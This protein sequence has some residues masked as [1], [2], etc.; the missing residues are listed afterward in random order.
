[1]VG[2]PQR[3]T[4]PAIAL[5]LRTSVALLLAASVPAA[6]G[7]PAPFTVSGSCRDARPH[8]AYEVHMQDG[9]LRVSGAFNQGKRI[10]SF[11]FWSSTGVRLALLPFDDDVMSG[12]VALWYATAPAKGE[13]PRKLE[14]V[15]VSGHPVSARSWY[16]DG[17][18]RAEFRYEKDALAEARAWNASGKRLPDAEARALAARD[19]AA[20][21]KFYDTLLAIVRDNPPSCDTNGR[22]A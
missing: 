22:K 5:A 10:G 7:A 18:P 3:V 12:T 8:G 1:M 19:L 4:P 11:L 14:A 16:P 9:R 15:Y 17:R 13:P 2:A 21:E 6:L 20:D